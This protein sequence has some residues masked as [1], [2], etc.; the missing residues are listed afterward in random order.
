MANVPLRLDPV[1]VINPPAPTAV[2]L[3]EEMI[4]GGTKMNPSRLVAPPGVV[5]LMAPLL[6][7]PTTARM[8]VEEIILNEATDVPPKVIEEVSNK[9]VPVIAINAPVA[10]TVGENWVMVGGGT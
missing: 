2:G 9:L 5:R 3:N 10:A 1:I 8:L 4:G 6:P 7:F